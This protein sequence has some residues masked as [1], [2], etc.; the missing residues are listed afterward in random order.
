M[1]LDYLQSIGV[2]TIWLSPHYASPMVDEGYDISNYQD[3]NPLFGTLA[4]V[5]ELIEQ[6]HNRQMKIIFDLVAAYTS[7]QHEWF[8]ESCSATEGKP[9]R[10]WYIWRPA[11]VDSNANRKPPTNWASSFG[12]SAWEWNEEREQ[13]Y[14]HT[15]T[16]QQPDLNWRDEECRKAIYENAIEFWL[17]R[18]LDGFRVDTCNIYS[19]PEIFTDA[20]ITKPEAEWQSPD[21]IIANGPPIHEYLKEMGQ[22][23][24]KYNAVSVGELGR[25]TDTKE[26]LKYVS[27][28]AKEL[29]MVFLFDV[30]NMAR[31]KG[32]KFSPKPW[33]VC[34]LAKLTQKLQ[35]YVD[36]HDAWQTTLLESHDTARSVSRFGN[37]S[38][39]FHSA[40]SKMLCVYMTMLS[41]TLILYQGMEIAMTNIPSF[42]S[43][44]EYFDV[45]TINFLKEQREKGKSETEI[46]QLMRGVNLL[47]RDNARTPI[48]WND[49]PNAGF[50]AANAKPWMRINDNYK[51]INI[52]QQEKDKDSVLNFY[53][54]AI[55]VRKQ[56]PDLFIY[57]RFSLLLDYDDKH[58]NTK[59]LAFTKINQSTFGKTANR[60]AKAVVLL[61]FSAEIQEVPV[62][63]LEQGK[64]ILSN[65]S[66]HDP[67]ERLQPY[68]S[69][70]MLV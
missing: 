64:I 31:V 63:D 47:A 34:E 44:G 43:Q 57:G 11:K 45:Q 14:L 32:E 5:D 36:D 62:D 25:S 66:P 9:K 20:P 15:Y 49:G 27:S 40:S 59:V 26:A 68:E 50:T 3:I 4:D 56:Y 51:Q 55:T 58:K 46:N 48:Q 42:W 41:G 8:Q 21:S 17:K 12:G 29:S 53:R 65:Y 37:D 22:I 33:T 24:E 60:L 69:R 2:D 16:K 30:V 28:S 18:G 23:F 61:N 52:R 10:D 54:K 39:K 13:Y 1:K 6:C 7:D 35:T 19:K 67:T 38:L 70:V